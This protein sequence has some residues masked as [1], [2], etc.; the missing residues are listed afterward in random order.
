MGSAQG[1]QC[2]Q[3]KG[4]TGQINQHFLQSAR[5]TILFNLSNARP[6][7][8]EL[9]GDFISRITVLRERLV[10]SPEEVDDATFI[11]YLLRALPTEYNILKEILYNLD[12]T[13]D[14]VVHRITH[15]AVAQ[16]IIQ[17]A[18]ANTSSVSSAALA[19][20]GSPYRGANANRGRGGR[21]FAPFRNP[22]I[23]ASRQN[24]ESTR[25]PEQRGIYASNMVCWD[26]GETGHGKSSCPVTQATPDQQAKG[27]AAYQEHQ[28][29]QRARR[30]TSSY[31]N[32]SYYEGAQQPPPAL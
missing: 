3:N 12:L 11:R 21:R 2:V 31:A 1:K 30:G 6:E 20:H 29:R 16:G 15:S 10:A 27:F 5:E 14:Q 32:V 22:L 13:V 4:K 23:L 17:P 8:G 19:A 25:R 9:I 26:C 28:D 24:R 18:S 7:H